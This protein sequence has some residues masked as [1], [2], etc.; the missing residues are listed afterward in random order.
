M[1]SREK[2]EMHTELVQITWSKKNGLKKQSLRLFILMKMKKKNDTTHY[3][4]PKYSQFISKKND[5]VP[6]DRYFLKNTMTF[7]YVTS[8]GDEKL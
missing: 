8:A 5:C 3:K 2:G 7:K 1:R 6:V 4:Q